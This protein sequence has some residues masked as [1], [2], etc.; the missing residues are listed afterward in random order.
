MENT[1]LLGNDF[2]KNNPLFTSTGVI[3][4]FSA[5]LTLLRLDYFTFDRHYCDGS[6]I[7]LTNA[8]DWIE[9]YW[10]AKLYESAIFEKDH[11]KFRDGHVF[12]SWLNRDPV[13]SAASLYGIDGGI[14]ISEKHENYCDFFNFGSVNNRSIT[15]DYLVECLPW[16]HQ[17]TGLFKYRMKDLISD[18]EKHKFPVPGIVNQSDCIQHVI[19]HANTLVDSQ[20]KYIGQNNFS[21]I[22]L[23]DD[24]GNSYLT[25]KEF[26]L[27][28][29]LAGG[30][31]TAEAGF[32]LE[33]S[34]DTINKHIKNITEK[35]N[36]KTLCEVGFSV[37]KI[38]SRIAYP[39]KN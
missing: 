14:T 28:M 23:G 13:Y 9:Y 39:F 7:S 3:V 11:L 29:L 31:T 35:L 4:E 27:V 6:R 21:R 26:E 2:Y 33:I 12:W 25:K 1:G 8:A 10:K 34:S 37:G 36:C 16:M 32:K 15:D 18:A 19:S 30:S 22:Y 38:A 5:P 24:F 20:H 17:F